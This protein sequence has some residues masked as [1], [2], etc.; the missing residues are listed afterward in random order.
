[1]GT[2]GAISVSPDRTDIF[3]MRPRSTN[4]NVVLYW[5]DDGSGVMTPR[6]GMRRGALLSLAER[7]FTLGNTVLL[8][9][10]ENQ[11]QPGRAAP[12]VVGMTIVRSSSQPRP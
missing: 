10:D 2:I 1:M 4:V 6:E 12:L 5:H 8:D 11:S 9:V 7:A 3:L